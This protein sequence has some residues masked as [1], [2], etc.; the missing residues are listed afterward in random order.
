MPRRSRSAAG[1]SSPWATIRGIV[2]AHT[3]VAELGA[4]LAR[5]DLVGVRSPREAITRLRRAAARMPRGQWILGQGWD[6]GAWAD[7][8]LLASDLDRAFPRN[9]VY[10]RGLHGFAGWA[11]TA[12]LQRAGVRRGT[13]DPVGGVIERTRDSIPTGRVRNR[14]VRLLDDAVP[15]PT[16]PQAEQH[17]LLGLGALARAGYTTVHEA[18]V[19][20]IHLDAL[21]ALAARCALPIRVYA[22]VSSRDSAAVRTALRDGPDTSGAGGATI[23]AAK[24]YYDGALGSRGARLFTDYADLPGQLGVAGAAYGFDS[25]AVA[26][27]MR[28]GFQVAIHAIGD[29]GNRE[30]IDFI[31][32]IAAESPRPALRRDRIEHAQV[33]APTDVQRIRDARI[34][35][36]I[37]P[38]HAVEDAPWAALRLGPERIK[39]AYAW[40]T[41]RDAAVP[42]TLG[43]DLPGSGHAIGYGLHAAVTRTDSTGKPSNGWFP[44]QR[45]NIEEALRGYTIWGQRASF[46]ELRRGMIAPGYDADLTV[47]DTDVFDPSAQLLR[48][49]PL[50]S[51][52][53]GRT[54]FDASRAPTLR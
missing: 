34:I 12:A 2:D 49:R 19:D 9:P 32:R 4:S 41:L 16:R 30:T 26:S 39:G 22:M 1:A 17:W 15:A 38:P 21:K 5:V 20:S 18:G 10:L 29:A 37:Q 40:R 50:L 14:A 51:I 44:E 25:S 11:N 48:A 45:L 53:G 6:E 23:R 27:L 46:V 24:A 47:L 7:T 43:S 54:A 8:T 31:S 13:P 42:L 36:S 28:R 33:V 35:A 52:V 3:H